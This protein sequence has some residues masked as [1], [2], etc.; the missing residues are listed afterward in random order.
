MKMSNLYMPTLREMPN[1]ADIESAQYLLRAGMIRKLVSGVYSYLPLGFRVM[2][3]VEQIVREEMDAYGS[4]EVLMSAIQPRE[5][6]EESNRWANFGPEMFRLKDR[7]DREFCL[8]PTH[9]EYFTFLINNELKSY[10]QLPLNLYQ[11]QTKY[12]DERRP[13][14]GLIRSREFIMKDAYTFDVDQEACEKS[15]QNM[16]D[17]YVSAF[18]RIG[19]KYKVVQGDSGNMGGSISHE[20]IAIT[21]NGESTI[22]YC[23]SCDFAGTDE[24][25]KAVFTLEPGVSGG[26]MEKIHTP[27]VTTIEALEA[28]YGFDAKQLIKAILLKTEDEKRFFAV[29]VPGHRTL[30]MTKLSKVLEVHEDSLMFANDADIMAMG[31][32]PGFSGPF[33]LKSHVE[34]Y[35]D[36]RVMTLKNAIC[37]ANEKDY[38]LKNV[39]LGEG[40]FKVV[41]DLVSVE[42]GDACPCC[43]KPLFIDRGTEVGNIFQLGDKYSK[44][45]NATFLDKDG[46]A[47]HFTMGSYGIG[48]SRCVAAVAEQC[49]DDKGI[50]WPL[51]IAPY[52]ALVT[53]VNVK[54]ELQLEK[55]LEIYS[56]LK[57]KGVEVL[58]DDRNER[59][60]VKFTD[61]DLIG[62]PLRITVGKAIETGMV[63]FSLRSDMVKEEI[64]LEN[65]VQRVIEAV[66]K[67]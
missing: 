43:G 61:A 56:A 22:A 23:D 37:G 59:A 35:V 9:E 66:E 51:A 38:H 54:N 29:F 24:V 16:W 58:I 34:V 5:L 21:P 14:F 45:L 50:A 40:A 44:A 62:I 52:Q 31:S 65:A 3:K 36:S 63:E 30:N 19:F 15:Y 10:K 4:Q 18:N 26:E 64:S 47:K 13:R 8:G 48:I 12:R 41:D 2:K 20:F 27:E 25:A 49:F 32:Y 55:G 67:I 7:H 28:N 53:V 57:S 39:T 46:K 6:W 60:G 33:D 1:D 17:A 11:I 42:A